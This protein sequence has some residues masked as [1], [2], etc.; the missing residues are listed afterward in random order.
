MRSNAKRTSAHT[1]NVIL[2][3]SSSTG[4][5]IFEAL[6]ETDFKPRDTRNLLL[7]DAGSEVQNDGSSATLTE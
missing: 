6:W 3:D 1:F 4:L 5:T 2:V 7:P